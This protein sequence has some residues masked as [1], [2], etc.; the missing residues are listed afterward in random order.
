MA[1]ADFLIDDF[2]RNVTS[3]TEEVVPREFDWQGERF[4]LD[5]GQKNHARLEAALADY[6]A[7]VQRAREKFEKKWMDP[8][9]PVAPLAPPR[10]PGRPAGGGNGN[11]SKSHKTDAATAEYLTGVRAWVRE[12]G[13]EIGDRGRVAGDVIEAYKAQD[14]KLIPA[15]FFPNGGPSKGQEEIPE[16]APA[17]KAAPAKRAPVAK[18]TQKPQEAP[19]AAESD[20]GGEKAPATT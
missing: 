6:E 7:E 10:K 8:A 11:G 5:L 2:D 1:K 18:T 20:K 15:R 4:T 19:Q 9:Q 14:R 12:Q 16:T 17:G 3:L 13:G